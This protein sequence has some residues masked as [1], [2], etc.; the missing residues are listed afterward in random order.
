MKTGQRPGSHSKGEGY[1]CH[2]NDLAGAR[3]G[4]CRSTRRRDHLRTGRLRRTEAFLEYLATKA[5]NA[6][7]YECYKSG[8]N[9]GRGTATKTTAGGLGVRR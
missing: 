2:L 8:V 7:D 9:I 3:L 1:A 4:S 5:G 6:L